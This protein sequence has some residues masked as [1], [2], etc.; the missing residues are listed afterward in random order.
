M[1]ALRGLKRKTEEAGLLHLLCPS[2]LL[3]GPIPRPDPTTAPG[4]QLAQDLFRLL[5]SFPPFKPSS[6]GL[7]KTS[8][9]L[10]LLLGPRP[11]F[12]GKPLRQPRVHMRACPV[13]VPYVP[14]RTSCGPRACTMETGTTTFACSSGCLWQPPPW[15]CVASGPGPLI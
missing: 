5:V 15:P 2:V 11:P 13:P 8:R 4:T 1:Q 6:W 7:S 14:V 3:P 12:L 9:A 10:P